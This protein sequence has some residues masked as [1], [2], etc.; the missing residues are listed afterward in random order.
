MELELETGRTHQIRVH[1]QFAG[2]PLVGDALYGGP[3]RLFARQ[4]LHGYKLEFAHP[5]SGEHMALTAP[6][7][8]DMTALWNRLQAGA[9]P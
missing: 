5:W 8:E 1:L 6:M 9:Q 3:V 4:A 2:A 7:P